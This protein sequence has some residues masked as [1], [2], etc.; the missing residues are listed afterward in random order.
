MQHRMVLRVMTSEPAVAHTDTGFAAMVELMAGNRVHTL[1]VVD[2]TGK[3]VGVVSRSDVLRVFLRPDHEIAED[4]DREVFRRALGVDPTTLEIRVSD[5]IVRLGGTVERRSW[6]S[7]VGSLVRQVDGVV[8]V[9]NALGYT[10]D[11]TAVTIPDA[12]AVDITAD[13][14][15]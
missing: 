9:V 7:V 12:M 6:V 8:D 2:R 5:G 13:P 10:W 15:R 14:R 11:D 3:F 4:I 1:P